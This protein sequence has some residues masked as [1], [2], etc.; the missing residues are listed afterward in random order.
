MTARTSRLLFPC[1]SRTAA[2]ASL[3]VAAAIVSAK[4]VPDNLGNG[5]DKI[6]ENDLINR[7]I[8][9][10][11]PA[12]QSSLS[13]TAQRN[14][15]TT[16]F[17]SYRAAV[18]KAAAK[19]DTVAIADRANGRYLVDVMPNGR[20]PVTTLQ[21]SL[22]SRFPFLTI[23]AI[24]TKYVGHG[25]IEGYVKLDDVPA[26]AKTQGVGSVIL[27]LKP[28]HRVGAVTEFGVNQHRVNRVS[29]LYNQAAAH[30]WDGNGMTIGV[31]S[32]SYDSQ[33]SVEGG[34]TTAAQDVATGDLPGTGNTVNS[35][36]VVVLQDFISPPNA[37]NEGRAMCQIV[38]D[39]APK[40]RIGFATA[41]VGE[42]GFA[43][44]IRALAGLA[45]YTYPPA[46]QQGFAA[47]V[48][49]DDV[50]YIDEPMFQDGIVAQ[51]VNDVVN[52]GKT[53]ASSAGNDMGTDG[54][55][56]VFRPIANGTGLTSA[57][58]SA[59]VGT[60]INLAGVPA[61][62]YAGG[63]HNFNA[64]GLDVAQTVNTDSDAG[65]FILQWN[66]PYDTSAPNLIEPPI[67][68]GNGTSTAG[69]EVS[70]GPFTFN[71]GQLYVITETGTPSLPTDNFD[72]I[73]RITDSNGKVWVDQDTGTDETVFFFA[74]QNTT[75]SYTVTVHPFA[76][77]PPVY[78]QGPFHIKINA[79][80][81][82]SGITQDFNVLFFDTAGN[83]ISALDTNSFVNNRPYELTQPSFNN[84]GFTQVQM[85]ISRSNTTAPANA[86]NQLRAIW[87]GNGASGIGPAE[88][89]NYLTPITY[90]HNSAAGANGVAAY[91]VFR[92]N[93]AQDFTS[94]GPVTIY[95]DANSQRLATPQVRL[96]P[97]IAAANGA[98]NT[99]FPIGPAPV[100]VDSQYDL[101]GYPNFYGTS[102]ASPHVGALAA[103]VLQAHG[104]P[105]SLTPQQVK[106]ILQMTAFPH[107]LDP[108]FSSG[109]ATAGNGGT[110]SITFSSDNSHNTGTGVN[111]P[112]AFTVSYSGPGR[113]A[114]LSFN[115]EATPQTG[116]NPTGGNFNGNP[117]GN[118]PSDFLVS[119]NY[120]STPGMVWT[121]TYLF[122]TSSGLVAGDVVHTRSNPAPFPANPSPGNPTAHQWTLNFT[123][124][125]NNFTN[126]KFFRF[127]NE[128]LMWQD[129]TTPQGQTV[130]VLFRN[131]D[132]Q[133]DSL[134][135]GVLL[136]EY[137]DTP[138]IKPGMTFSGTIVDGA[139]TYPFSGRMTNKIGKGYSAQDGFGFINLEA[140][141]TATLPVPGVASRKTHGAAG[142]FDIPL[143]INGPAG[144]ECRAPGAG[145]SYQLVF[146]FDRS[147]GAAG[148]ASATQGTATAA[149]PVMG[150]NVN[151]VTVNLTGVTNAQ[152]L[153]VT[154]SNARD[155]SGDTFTP[156]AARMDVL[157]GDVGGNR[158]VNSTDVSQVKLQ[159]GVAVTGS[160]FRND[161]NANGAINSSDVSSVKLA[162]GTA[163]P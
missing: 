69:S 134:G 143:P 21:A 146:T 136:P 31:L 106:T 108:F 135:D 37:T 8:I 15:L 123:F 40:A 138:V 78:T 71:P 132:Y 96:K 91:D 43:N 5:L 133:A 148:N 86:A 127:N 22:Q 89:R 94:P 1:L 75:N 144:V 120:D 36:P 4:P 116:G 113:V 29:T 47:D 66:D 97:D 162:S 153:V 58:N 74:P 10:S 117:T 6:V 73:V 77:Q 87:L 50:L 158:T 24:D 93:I 25:V 130:P 159:S 45:G 149:A 60:N 76:Q 79:A 145:G 81:N 34:F 160:N 56:S 139:T 105:G 90:G 19:F 64:G 46:T 49:C 99:F 125:N 142:T 72:G 59:L 2:L 150:P 122:G 102:A 103:L 156:A 48:V 110:V 155:T 152:H 92:P 131:G 41:D 62:L 20:V 70:F 157:F 9:T 26:I 14:A 141:T 109:S 121:S 68:E 65:F 84:D 54:Y 161:I 83:F 17:A 107:D 67:F 63:F 154:L 61:A 137:A 128:R 114:S 119:A 18:A 124:P 42:L 80:T 55:A 115:P 88:Y 44:N 39:I 101:D 52:A 35:Q 151:Q 163:L 112:N 126:G 85:V 28:M 100:A 23:T 27:Q 140:A 38:H 33:P 30:N 104:G 13:K 95:F 82:V 53:Y 11:V 16:N 12:G 111:D 57:T 147:V 32:D 98:N 118:M 51:G 3:A 129:A 7:G